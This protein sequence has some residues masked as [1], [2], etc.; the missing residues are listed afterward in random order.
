MKTRVRGISAK[1]DAIE[2]TGAALGRDL[3]TGEHIGSVGIGVTIV[4]TLLGG[5]GK[6]A[7]EAAGLAGDAIR[8]IP[9]NPFRGANAPQR[10]FEHLE[11][12]S[13]LDPNVAS[14]RLHRL[15]KMGGLAADDV[16]VIGRTGD[17]LLLANTLEH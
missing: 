14:A 10:A 13:G 15:K 12:Y 1:E 8:K 11:K 4:G 3:L 17:V 16:M 7:R 6:L 9:G 5:S 2:I